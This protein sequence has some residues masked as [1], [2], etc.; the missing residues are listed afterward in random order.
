MDKAE[1]ELKDGNVLQIK[2]ELTFNTVTKLWKASEKLLLTMGPKIRIDL[3]GVTHSDSASLALLTGWQ[4]VAVKNDKSI[5]F[6][7]L[8]PQLMN[9]VKISRLDEVLNLGG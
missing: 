5:E 7:H 8:P 3:S 9:I 4:R 2:G 1:F 6:E